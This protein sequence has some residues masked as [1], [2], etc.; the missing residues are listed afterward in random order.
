LQE[1]GQGGVTAAGKP[2]MRRGALGYYRR[3]LL[4]DLG[5]PKMAVLFTSLLPQF[6]GR[7]VVWRSSGWCFAR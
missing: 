4:S 3:G 6:G 5:N 7:F 1:S 2:T